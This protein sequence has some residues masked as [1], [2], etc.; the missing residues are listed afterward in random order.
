[1]NVDNIYLKTEEKRARK[2]PEIA[3]AQF[4]YGLVIVGLAMIQAENSAG[5]RRKAGD[6][7]NSDPQE[8][9][10]NIEDRVEVVTRALATVILP[11]IDS[12]GSLEADDVGALEPAVVGE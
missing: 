10:E 9:E 5:T 7:Q 2:E 8:G 12:L 6:E 3:E 1:M 11:I 4:I